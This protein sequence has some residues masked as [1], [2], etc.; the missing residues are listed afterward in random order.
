[1]IVFKSGC[2]EINHN[3]MLDLQVLNSWQMTQDTPIEN[4]Q[5]IVAQVTTKFKINT[6]LAGTGGPA[7]SNVPSRAAALDSGASPS[8]AN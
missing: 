1:M 7:R 2:K 4:G 8:W 3:R 5:F 6:A